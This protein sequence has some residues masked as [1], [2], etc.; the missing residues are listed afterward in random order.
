MLGLGETLEEVGQV[1]RDLRAHGCRMLTLGQYLQPSRHHL[2]VSRFVT[3]QE[4]EQLAHEAEELGFSSVASGPM[5]R[6]SYHADL[7]A[8][9]ENVR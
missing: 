9:G 1:M 4:F 3:P 2:P 5:V 6:S 8:R 7:Q